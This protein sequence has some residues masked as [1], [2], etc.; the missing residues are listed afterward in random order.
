MQALMKTLTTGDLTD[1]V[2]RVPAGSAAAVIAGLEGLFALSGHSLLPMDTD[3]EPSHSLAEVFPER[4]PAMLLRGYRN[5]LDMTQAQLAEAM[6]VTQ[7]RVSEWE[8]GKRPVSIK[9][10]KKLAGLFNV[11]YQKF[12]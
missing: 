4:S 11:P 9:A 12:L 2:L 3:G 10:A 7:A 1:I 5:K 6:Q 8:S